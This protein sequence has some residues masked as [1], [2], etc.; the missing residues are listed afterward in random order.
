MDTTTKEEKNTGLQEI[1]EDFN[2][3]FG[4]N[5]SISE[6]DKFYIECAGKLKARNWFSYCSRYV[7]KGLIV[8]SYQQSI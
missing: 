3:D 5:H 7:V 2:K 6:T 1:I 8:I 4:T